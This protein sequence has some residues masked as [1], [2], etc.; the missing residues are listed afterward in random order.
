MA[1]ELKCACLVGSLRKES[2]NRKL[3]NAAIAQAPENLKFDF[4]D[5]GHLP[6][7]NQDDEAQAPASWVDFRDQIRAHDAMLF[8]T[9]EYNRGVP[10]TIKNAIDVGSRPPG[11]NVFDGKPAAVMSASAGALGGYGGN[12]DLC[13]PNPALNM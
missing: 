3:V 2:F 7:Y 13:G 11:K 5:I 6:Y 8:V 12:Q 9:P 10:A 1:T 4:L